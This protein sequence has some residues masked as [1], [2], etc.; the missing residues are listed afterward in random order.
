MANVDLRVYAMEK[1]VKMYQ[2]AKEYGLS[3]GHFC[4][5]MRDEFSKEEKKKIKEII[6]SIAGK[7]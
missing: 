4:K 2:V 5:K 7:G 6:D 1:G 3:E